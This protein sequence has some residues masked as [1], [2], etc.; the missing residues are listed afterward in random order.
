VSAVSRRARRGVVRLCESLAG[1]ASPLAASIDFKRELEATESSDAAL[2]S[3]S[4]DTL[5][6]YSSQAQKSISQKPPGNKREE[7]SLACSLFYMLATL[8]LPPD[9]C[10]L[11]PSDSLTKPQSK[12]NLFLLN[13]LFDRSRFN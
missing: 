8:C 2:V 11:H 10:F 6:I 7:E 13:L 5:N 3:C 12:S 1:L 9:V 4:I